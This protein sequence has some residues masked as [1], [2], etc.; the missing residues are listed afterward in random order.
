RR[1]RQR[2]GRGRAHRHPAGGFRGAMKFSGTLLAAALAIT[3]HAL[4]QEWPAK[5]VRMIVPFP[6]GTAPDLVARLL[7]ERLG[8]AWRTQV[9]VENRAGAAGVPGMKALAQSPADGYTLA[10]APATTMT[11]APVLLKE[12]PYD[13]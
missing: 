3:Q 12:P 10:L 13:V 5:P 7:G 6:A 2:Q 8:A 4:A 11:L 9:P 1:P